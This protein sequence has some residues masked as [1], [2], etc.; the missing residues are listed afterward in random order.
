METTGRG[1]LPFSRA[2]AQRAT[3]TGIDLRVHPVFS[4]PF[5]SGAFRERVSL[6]AGRWH[7]GGWLISQV[8]RVVH[9]I[10]LVIDGGARPAFPAPEHHPSLLY[11]FALRLEA[12]ALRICEP[13]LA[14]AAARCPQI[15]ASATAVALW[16]S[17]ADRAGASLLATLQVK[18]SPPNGHFVGRAHGASS[19]SLAYGETVVLVMAGEESQAQPSGP[20]DRNS[21]AF[22]TLL[23]SQQAEVLSVPDSAWLPRAFDPGVEPSH[24][25]PLHQ[26]AHPLLG[27]ASGL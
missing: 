27:E 16:G 11:Q 13:A 8:E 25:S 1:L 23:P 7:D 6:D 9:T 17:G 22:G 21:D 18:T 2:G 24:W 12:E 19:G 3:P 20:R 14:L 5:S 15:E 26:P 4:G 10:P